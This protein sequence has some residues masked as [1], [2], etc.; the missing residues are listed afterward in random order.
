MSH[1]QFASHLR[2]ELEQLNSI[3]D[4]KIVRG[5]DYRV[6]AT[7]HREL[8]RSLSRMKKQRSFSLNFLSFFF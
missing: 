4:R 8:L 2:R 3:I 5:R 1:Y 6:E 7:R